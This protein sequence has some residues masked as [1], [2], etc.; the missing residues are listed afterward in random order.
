MPCVNSEVVS[1]ISCSR[2]QFCS[3]R[4]LLFAEGR[5]LRVEDEDAQYCVLNSEELFKVSCTKK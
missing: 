1:G 3:D 2:D 4:L 5:F